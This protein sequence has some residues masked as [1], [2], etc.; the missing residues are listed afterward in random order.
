MNQYTK[1]KMSSVKPCFERIV[2]FSNQ[3]QLEVKEEN[4]ESE[5]IVV[6]NEDK[7]VYNLVIDCEFPILI[8]EQLVCTVQNPTNEQLVRLLQ[9]NR[10]L[11]HGAFVLDEEAKH[12]IFRDTLQLENLD[13]NEFEGTINALSLGLAEYS[14]ELIN[15]SNK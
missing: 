8:F 5:L 11:V 3:L 1:G 14:E 6:T 13:F 2:D 10:T 7:G 15:I 12:I 4:Q 9:M